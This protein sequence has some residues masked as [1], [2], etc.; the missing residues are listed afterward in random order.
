MVWTRVR[1]WNA[2]VAAP[3]YSL[4][5]SP[6][7]KLFQELH[8]APER[9]GSSQDT[10]LSSATGSGHHGWH[11]LF[12]AMAQSGLRL[13]SRP[14]LSEDGSGLAYRAHVAFRRCAFLLGGRAGALSEARPGRRSPPPVHPGNV[15][16]E[17]LPTFPH[18]S[19]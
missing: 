7:G 19:P 3:C 13:T 2:C 11:G 18:H 12:H 5:G 9:P 10:T 8:W 16:Q 14:W 15:S 6:Y 17:T 1:G 4:L